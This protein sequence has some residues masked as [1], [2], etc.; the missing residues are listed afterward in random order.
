MPRVLLLSGTGSGEDPGS[1]GNGTWCV[2]R[3]LGP[4]W[5]YLW[6]QVVA[7]VEPLSGGRLLALGDEGGGLSMAD[8]R[9]LGASNQGAHCYG[10][11]RGATTAGYFSRPYLVTQSPSKLVNCPHQ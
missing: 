3:T 2:S 11:R 4:S 1:L 8:L 5:K 6:L 10:A 9:M 7:R